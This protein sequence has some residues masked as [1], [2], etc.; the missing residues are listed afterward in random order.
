MECDISDDGDEDAMRQLAGILGKLRRRVEDDLVSEGRVFDVN[1]NTIGRW[2]TDIA[3]STVPDRLTEQERKVLV[4]AWA[5]ADASEQAVSPAEQV[6]A[7]VRARR[8]LP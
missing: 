4:E 5:L 8:P 7:K 2:T 3:P 1:G 6:L